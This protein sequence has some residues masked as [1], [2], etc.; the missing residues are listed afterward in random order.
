MQKN[1]IT[2]ESCKNDLE[3][4]IKANLRTLVLILPIMLVIFVP[5]TC[6]FLSMA[7]ADDMLISA[8][9][10]CGLI[11]TPILAALPTY[12][13]FQLINELWEL[14]MISEYKFSIVK[15]TVTRTET[16]FV[17]RH[18]EYAA[19]FENYGKCLISRT[20]Y[21]LTSAKDEYYIVILNCNKKVLCV[22][23]TATN[24]CKDVTE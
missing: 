21:D 15:D 18:E 8:R 4:G 19:H 1:N 12:F 5:L 10:I 13:I 9:L 14:K 7:L 24:E 20:Q 23:P 17:R 6:L 2:Y 3:K 11:F 16:V 22:Y